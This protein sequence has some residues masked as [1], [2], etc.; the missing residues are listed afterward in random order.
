MDDTVHELLRMRDKVEAL[1]R[2]VVGVHR[3]KDATDFEAVARELQ[4]LSAS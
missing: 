1:K 2:R 3:L 4:N